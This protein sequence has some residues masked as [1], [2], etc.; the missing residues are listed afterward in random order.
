MNFYFYI[1]VVAKACFFPLQGETSN[2]Q[3][4]PGLLPEEPCLLPAFIL[5]QA[6]VERSNVQK[7]RKNKKAE[8]RGRVKGIASQ[9]VTIEHH[10]PFSCGIQSFL[11][12]FLG[13]PNK[14]H[15]FA[16]HPMPKKDTW[17]WVVRRSKFISN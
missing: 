8:W 15:K 4:E 7:E 6:C 2:N 1:G 5:N 3:L 16:V 12:F 10:H 17:Y 14:P 9:K 11:K 13:G